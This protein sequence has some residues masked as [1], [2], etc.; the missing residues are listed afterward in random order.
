MQYNVFYLL[1]SGILN[2]ARFEE[3]LKTNKKRERA[4]FMF[5]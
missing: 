3:L 4:L 5:Y 1:N 2:G